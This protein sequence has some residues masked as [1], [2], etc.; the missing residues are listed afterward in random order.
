MRKSAM[1]ILFAAL[2]VAPQAVPAQTAAPGASVFERSIQ[3]RLVR[4]GF[5]DI[6]ATAL[7]GNQQAGIWAAL[8]STDLL[9][10]E[11]VMR[12]ESILYGE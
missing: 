6:D 2:A 3:N 7:T 5:G 4:Y 12:V 8:S 11:K 9:R 1:A 10:T